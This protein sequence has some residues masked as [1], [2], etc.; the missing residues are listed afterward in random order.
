MKVG[1]N[2]EHLA[3]SQEVGLASRACDHRRNPIGGAKLKIAQIVVLC[4]LVFLAVSSGITKIM[5]MPQD[6]AFFG[7]YGFT[8][9]L[10]MLFGA[11]QVIGGAMMVFAKTRLIGAVIVAVTFVISAIVLIMAGSVPATVA[12]LIALVFLG[13]VI[14]RSRA[15]GSPA[16]R[17]C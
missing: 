14:Q 8:H 12:T 4:S 2:R 15:A 10:L 5:L 7:Q 13:L 3:S 9:P 6:V 11:I 17:N 1:T 16:S